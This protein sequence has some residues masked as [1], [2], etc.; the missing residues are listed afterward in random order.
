MND[1][2]HAPAFIE[3]AFGNDGVEAG[4]CAQD[5]PAGDDVL[6]GVLGAGIIQAAFAL[7]PVHGLMHFGRLL[8][9]EP[10]RNLGR[11]L[12]AL[13]AQLSYLPQQHLHPAWLLPPPQST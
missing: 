5:G 11:W 9:D 6:D 1:E 4:Y 10:G 12:A 2:V 8:V 13:L 7:K 3:E